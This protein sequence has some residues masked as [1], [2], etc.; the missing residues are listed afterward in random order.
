MQITEDFGNPGRG[1]NPG[2]TVINP[3]SQCKLAK[4]ENTE[5][6]AAYKISEKLNI[7]NL[8]NTEHAHSSTA[9]ATCIWQDGKRLI[10]I[11]ESARR[12]LN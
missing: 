5:K 12:I 1:K 11:V 2:G 3:F 10:S 9:E 4:A 6:N 8:L 7:K